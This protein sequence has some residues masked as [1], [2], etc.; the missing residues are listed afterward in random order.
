MYCTNCGIKVDDSHRFCAGCGSKVVDL[1]HVTKNGTESATIPVTP[2]VPGSQT[3]ADPACSKVEQSCCQNEPGLWNPNA[4]ANWS[5]VFTP[6][7][8]ATI[9]AL[10]SKLLGDRRSYVHHCYWLVANS[11][12]YAMAMAFSIQASLVDRESFVPLAIYL[13]SLLL[14][15]FAACRPEVS[16]VKDYYR[17]GTTRRGWLIPIIVGVGGRIVSGL[18]QFFLLAVLLSQYY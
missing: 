1:G 13:G 8:G 4:A 3:P 7:F 14:W 16:R 15:Y 18:V 5:L 6:I 9:L 2:M 17:S 12:A 10:N 11:I